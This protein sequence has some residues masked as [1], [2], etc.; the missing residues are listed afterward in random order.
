MKAYEKGCFFDAWGEYYKNDLW[1]EAF[2]ECGLDI[3]FYTTRE[4][5]LDEILPWDFID[6]GVTKEYLKREWNRALLEECTPNCRVSCQG[7]GAARYGGGVCV[8][9]KGAAHGNEN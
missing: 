7:C 2:R 8:E 6:C 4:R 3:A 5:S 9:E 1:L